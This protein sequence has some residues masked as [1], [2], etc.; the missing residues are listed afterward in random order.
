MAFAKAKYHSIHG[1]IVSEWR[2]ENGIF[3]LHVTVPLGTSATVFLPGKAAIEVAAG[4]HS[5]DTT[6]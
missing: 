5:F 6:L 4:T 2:I 3:K 1:D